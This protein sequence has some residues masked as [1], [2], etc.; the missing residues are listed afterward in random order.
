VIGFF[1]D[2]SSDSAGVFKGVAN[3]FRDDI[4]FGLSTSADLARAEGVTVPAVVIFKKFDDP[5]VVHK[6]ELTQAALSQFIKGESFPLVGEIGPENYKKYVDRELP[7]VW[8]FVS[9]EDS[10]TTTL[11]E[12]LAQVAKNFRTLSFVKLDGVK[13]GSHAKNF[14]LG[15][16]LPGLVI[17]DRLKHKNYVYHND[18]T[19]EALTAWVKSF[20]EGTLSATLKSQEPPATQDE[21]VTVL[22]GKTFDAIVNDP[23]KDVLVEFYAPWCGHC[24]TLA[25]KYD[26]LAKEFKAHPSVVIAKI[27]ATENDSPADIKGFP[28]LL[29]YPSNNKQNPLT[30]KGERSKQAIG[31]WLRENC[32]TLKNTGS[33][34]ASHGHADHTHEDL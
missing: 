32:P 14:G 26:E 1:S 25:P 17:E 9:F 2:D 31:D 33:A 15:T 23:T 28:T 13:W 22:V 30:F 18:V 8:A 29:F 16:T 10:A 7:I 21:P 27:D 11:L 12:T 3:V 4:S 5:K 34:S 24:K 6:G 19:Q 20:V